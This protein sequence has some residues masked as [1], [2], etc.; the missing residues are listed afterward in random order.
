MRLRS[1]GIWVDP[2]DA[3]GL[4]WA[5][6]NC[7][8]ASYHVD[9]ARRLRFVLWAT[10]DGGP[11]ALHHHSTGVRSNQ[12]GHTVALV[13]DHHNSDLDGE[14][15]M[16]R[17]FVCWVAANLGDRKHYDITVEYEIDA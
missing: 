17:G 10:G 12:G 5:T 3:C 9:K 8:R 1:C 6:E 16:C 14:I 4:P 11:E 7:L 13:T 15:P 2:S